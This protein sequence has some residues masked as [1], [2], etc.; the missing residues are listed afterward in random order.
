MPVLEHLQ[1]TRERVVYAVIYVIAGNRKQYEVYCRENR[2][3]PEMDARYIDKAESVCGIGT[4]R[5][6][7]TVKLVGTYSDRRDFFSLVEWLKH[8]SA[9][10]CV[11]LENGGQG[12]ARRQ[13][14]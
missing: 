2:F 9:S 8:E 13:L 7:A 1:G 3:R 5:N 12:N 10:G 4:R 6:P 11:K 14:F